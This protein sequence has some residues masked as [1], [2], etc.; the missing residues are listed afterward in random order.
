MLIG[1]EYVPSEV[2]VHFLS[3]VQRAQVL[4]QEPQFIPQV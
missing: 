1:P 3:I 4:E 2:V